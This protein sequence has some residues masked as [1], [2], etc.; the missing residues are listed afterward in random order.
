MKFYD[1]LIIEKKR[2]DVSRYF[3]PSDALVFFY[4]DK[5]DAFGVEMVSG[6][7]SEKPDWESMDQQVVGVDGKVEVPWW[8]LETAGSVDAFLVAPKY[9]VT[10]G[11]IVGLSLLSVDE[12]E[13]P[14]KPKKE[15]QSV[16]EFKKA[17]LSEKMLKSAFGEK[18]D[19]S[20]GA[21]EDGPLGAYTDEL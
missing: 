16:T 11:K 13:K 18:F 3:R 5:D 4:E 10:S 1:L 2:I 17:D 8:V 6:F 9:S 21:E 12:V 20:A 7:D 19:T 15:K 14:K